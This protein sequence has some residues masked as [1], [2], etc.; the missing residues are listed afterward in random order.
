MALFNGVKRRDAAGIRGIESSFTDY[1]IRGDS[2][3]RHTKLFFS[4]NEIFERI[5]RTIE[6][7]LREG[8]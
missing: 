6:K 4:M 3:F 1:K 2:K 7:K 5:K 8:A